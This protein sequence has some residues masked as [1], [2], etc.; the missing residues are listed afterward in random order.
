MGVLFYLPVSKVFS[1]FTDKGYAFSRTL[2]IFSTAYLSWVL[3][4]F[5]TPNILLLIINGVVFTSLGVFLIKNRKLIKTKKVLLVEEFIYLVCFVLY[6]L[7]RI[8]NP[9][10]EG[11]EKFMDMAIVNNLAKTTFLPPQDVW[12]SQK[13]INYY[14]FGQMEVAT[15]I[16]IFGIQGSYFYNLFLPTLFANTFLGIFSTALT[17]TN[18]YKYGVLASLLV[19]V[20]GNLDLIYQKLQLTRNYYYAGAR[21]L[22]DKAITEFPAYS[23][24]IGDLHAHILNL[25]RVIV[26][27]AIV[28]SIFLNKKVSRAKTLVLGFIL[29]SLFITNSWDFVIYVPLVTIIFGVIALQTKKFK[30]NLIVPFFT[31]IFVSILSF[32]PFHLTFKPAVGGIGLTKTFSGIEPILLMFGCF[33][34]FT[35]CFVVASLV[36]K[37]FKQNNILILLFVFY[38]FSIIVGTEII[39]IKDIYFTANP[40]YFRANTVFKMWYQAWL[41]LGISASYA[42]Y[43]V[44]NNTNKGTKYIFVTLCTLILISVFIYP[45][46]GIYYLVRTNKSLSYRG[47]NG[48]MFLQDEL[49]E[50]KKAIEWLNTSQKTPVVIIEKPGDAYTTDSLFSVFTGNPTAVGWTNHEYG[51]RGDWG[52]IAKVIQDVNTIYTSTNIQEVEKML[53][54]YNVT[55][56]IIGSKEIEKYGLGAGKTVKEIGQVIYNN[57][58]VNIVKIK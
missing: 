22:L 35:V 7:F 56:V 8:Y 21:S 38:G 5:K 30:R 25:P 27:L 32:L 45:I 31:V 1:N 58:S 40:E 48:T 6:L 4:H 12:Y 37:E 53:D 52:E 24:L 39:F 9:K 46:N 55:Y 44:I 50:E 34:F 3:L 57:P 13:L 20:S 28:S 51:W 10:I 29:G 26:T 43:Y 19:L 49:S 23:F 2:G 17:L 42:I 54:K 41:I 36:K 15:L 16:R 11:I 33:I 14:Y 47:L 18:K